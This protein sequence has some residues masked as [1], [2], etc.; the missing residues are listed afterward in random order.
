MTRPV[1]PIVPPAFNRYVAL[2]KLK[3]LPVGMR[4]YFD[5]ETYVIRTP[6]QYIAYRTWMVVIPLIETFPPNQEGCL[7]NWLEQ[8]GYCFEGQ[9]PAPLQIA[10]A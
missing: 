6:T 8:F 10:P 4:L 5:A 9:P 1:Y 7:I 2:L 3:N